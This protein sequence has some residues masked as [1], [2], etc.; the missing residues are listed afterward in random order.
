MKTIDALAKLLALEAKIFTTR[1][2]VGS[3]N[4][5]KTNASKLL[6]RLQDAGLATRL[7]WGIWTLE[8]SIDPLVL[9]EYLTAP[10]P[11]YVSLHT[12]LYYHEMVSQIP[13]VT[14]AVTIGRTKS[15]DTPFGTVSVHHVDPSFYFGFETRE[16][17]IKFATPEKALLDVFYLSTAKTRLFSALPEV[18]LPEQFDINKAH[19]IIEQIQSRRRKTLVSNLFQEFLKKRP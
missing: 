16:D 9:P 12:A 17:E 8:Q 3:L 19:K 18:S 7:A 13:S 15:F 11:S 10:F 6:S 1:D 2:V 4:V 5:S 14:Y